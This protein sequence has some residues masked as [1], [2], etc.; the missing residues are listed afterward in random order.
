MSPASSLVQELF[1]K[2][3]PFMTFGTFFLLFGI[4]EMLIGLLFIIRGAERAVTPLLL[5]HMITTFMPLFMLPEMVWSQF[6]V[7]T[8]EGQY[9]IKNLVVIAAAVTVAAN[10]HPVR[11]YKH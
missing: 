3:V 8:L 2:T 5:V 11:S 6:L 10:L 7:P 1:Q 9:I 4:F